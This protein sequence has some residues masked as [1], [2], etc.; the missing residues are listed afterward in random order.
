MY[1]SSTKKIQE[2]LLIRWV[3]FRLEK[4]H[5]NNLISKVDDESIRSGSIFDLLMETSNKTEQSGVGGLLRVR[6]A[7]NWVSSRGGP[8]LNPD[9][10]IKGN[11]KQSTDLL[12]AMAFNLEVRSITFNGLSGVDGLMEWIQE[13][14]K[15]YLADQILTWDDISSM[16]II[17]L[18]DSYTSIQYHEMQK[19]KLRQNL[20]T[21]ME[22]AKRECGIP[23]I[24]DVDDLLSGETICILLYLAVGFHILSNQVKM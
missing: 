19:Y 4:I 18:I 12:W 20:I 14:T 8:S 13:R 10:I 22:A 9:L 11:I 5:S 3:N 24:V 21:A 16:I 1:N 17:Q 6:R 7:V 15:I 23:L 2:N